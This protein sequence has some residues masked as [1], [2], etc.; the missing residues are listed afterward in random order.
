MTAIDEIDVVC[1]SVIKDETH[2]RRCGVGFQCVRPL[3]FFGTILGRAGVEFKKGSW[4]EV[5]TV[6]TWT[7]DD[8]NSMRSRSFDRDL[9]GSPV[10][11]APRRTSAHHSTECQS[12]W[13]AQKSL[14]SRMTTLSGDWMASERWYATPTPVIPEPMMHTSASAINGPVLPSRANILTSGEE[15]AQKERVGFGDG[16]PA[17][18]GLLWSTESKFCWFALRWMGSVAIAHAVAIEINTDIDILGHK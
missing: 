10:A 1:P 5:A 7:I 16:K 3:G 13:N 12:A 17:G 15:S 14:A 11:P 18:F 6:A 4:C 8:T 2:E 9:Y